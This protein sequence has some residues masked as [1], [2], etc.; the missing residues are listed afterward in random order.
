[1][2]QTIEKKHH[3]RPESRPLT[4]VDFAE[5]SLRL[6][7]E[8]LAA[9]FGLGLVGENS[10]NFAAVLR[11]TQKH[12][13]LQ[14]V[15]GDSTSRP[16]LIDFTGGAFRYRT[17][18]GGAQMILK[19]LGIKKSYRPTVIDVTGGMGRD[20]FLIAS[21]GCRVSLYERNPVVAA[22]L[23]DG[24]ARAAAHPDTGETAKRIQLVFGDA[25][26]A[27]EEMARA[28]ERTDIVYLDPMFPKRSKAAK[29]KKDLQT[30]QFLVGQNDDTEELFQ[31]A[32]EVASRRVVVKRP[33]KAA[34]ITDLQ[35]SHK[36][37]GKTT[38]F[39]VYM[40]T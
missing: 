27:L 15:R 24:L 30:L 34:S 28:G 16:L 11:L 13:E 39:D 26:T 18:H 7:A 21:S 25:V 2:N 8:Q 9:D 10:S 4:G 20:S 37:E 14:I 19:A 36:I 31:R 1:M 12:L 32:M 29:V 33:R 40:I 6:A 5:E 35:P 38:R 23:Q 3:D 17:L 22:L